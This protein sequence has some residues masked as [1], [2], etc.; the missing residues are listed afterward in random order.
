[1][2]AY[3]TA[4]GFHRVRVVDCD[5]SKQSRMTG[6]VETNA[7]G[8]SPH[9]IVDFNVRPGGVMYGRCAVHTRRCESRAR[10][11]AHGGGVVVV[12]PS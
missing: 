5:L 4:Y 11:S 10:T 12:R 6:C 1:M 7:A 3:I 8:S 9:C 2:H